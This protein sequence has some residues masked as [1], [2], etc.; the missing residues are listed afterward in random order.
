MLMAL[1][2]V[3]PPAPL[4]RGPSGKRKQTSRWRK[5]TCTAAGCDFAA[6]MTRTAFERRVLRCPDP[7]CRGALRI[8]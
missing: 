7:D 5:V 1:A 8:E 3:S 6:R 4:R 2:G